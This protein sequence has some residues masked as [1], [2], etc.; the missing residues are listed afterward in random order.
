MTEAVGDRM[1]DYIVGR[2]PGNIRIDPDAGAHQQQH[3]EKQPRKNGTGDSVVISE[4][5]R[6]RSAEG[7]EDGQPEDPPQG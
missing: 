1:T 4:E 3:R 2:I 7:A 6:K 5:A